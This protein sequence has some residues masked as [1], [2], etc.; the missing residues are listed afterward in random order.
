MLASEV[1]RTR[2]EMLPPVPPNIT[3][4]PAPMTRRTQ[5]ILR[6]LG[7]GRVQPSSTGFCVISPLL[8]SSQIGIGQGSNGLA[9][10]TI[11]KNIF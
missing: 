3:I 4:V 9:T 11:V 10:E 1:S 5:H 7:H 2:P 6:T 8:D